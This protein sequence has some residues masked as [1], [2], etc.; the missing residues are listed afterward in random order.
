MKLGPVAKLDKRKKTRQ[1]NL[2]I[3]SCR[4]IMTS[5]S[6]FEFR[7]NLEQSG[8]LIPS[9]YSIK[10]LFSLIVTLYLPKTENRTKMSLAQLSHYSFD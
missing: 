4:K 8:R 10:L 3:I 5:L 1:K 2:T 9:A 7:D 6:F